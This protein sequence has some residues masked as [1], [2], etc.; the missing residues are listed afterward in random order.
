MPSTLSRPSPHPYITDDA[1]IAALEAS[2]LLGEDIDPAL[3]RWTRLASELIDAPVAL[4]SLV[5]EDRQFFK[6]HSGLPDALAQARQTP[7]SHSFCQ[8]VVAQRAPLVIPDARVDPLVADNLAIPDIGVIAYA[9]QPVTDDDGQVLGSFCVIDTTPRVWTPQELALLEDLAAGLMGEIRLR[10]ALR[11]SLALQD[12]LALQARADALT[13]LANRRQLTDDLRRAVAGDGPRLLAMFDLD[14]FKLYNDAFGHPAGDGLLSRLAHKLAA[15][16]AEHGGSAYRLGGDEFCVLVDGEDAVAAAGAALRESGEGFT[17]TSSHGHVR[18]DDGGLSAD[19]AMQ[20][21]DE[22]LYRQKNGRSDA[23]R[24][25]AQ[26]VL[27]GV[28]REREPALDQHVREVAALAHRVGER[29]ELDGPALEE[30]GL[31]AEMHD[32][33]K[34]A[35]PD[36]ILDKPGPLTAE[37]WAIMRQHTIFGERI[38][39]AAPALRGVAELVRAS[40]ERWDGDGYPDGRA[41]SEIPFAARIVLACDAFCAMTAARPYA[42]A[43]TAAQAVEELRANAGTQ[44]D[45]AVVAALTTIVTEAG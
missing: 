26:D 14:G 7:L 13:G 35:V 1:R 43:R 36:S 30:L 23:A 33:G 38:L 39:T 17:I 20:V 19:Q 34:V 11:M 6:S 2:G 3:D 25:Q 24:R 9:G 16:V 45:P 4:L 44:F 29:L 8:H 18:L 22:R 5:T 31:A 15:V 28:L 27:L 32:I 40:H 21:A 37:E 12:D 42:A 10:A 41:G